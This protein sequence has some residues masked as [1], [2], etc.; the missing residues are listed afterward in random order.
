MI[1]IHALLAESDQK[2][3]GYEYVVYISIHA[4]LAESDV[5]TILSLNIILHISIHALLAESDLISL[6]DRCHELIS[7]HALLAE[8]DKQIFSLQ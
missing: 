3:S 1:S 7:I 6:C 4:L 8:S 2:V 5:Y